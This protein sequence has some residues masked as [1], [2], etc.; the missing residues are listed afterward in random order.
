[1]G[2]SPKHKWMTEYMH[3]VKI[4]SPGM[5]LTTQLPV[6]LGATFLAVAVGA[7]A[8]MA[9]LSAHQLQ[10]VC[11][12]ALLAL[13]ILLVDK[14]V[15]AIPTIL[16]P[17]SVLFASL[18]LGSIATSGI[19]EQQFP[20]YL[21]LWACEI[22]G[23]L[24]GILVFPSLS[25]PASARRSYVDTERLAKHTQTIWIIC[26]LAA[27]LFFVIQGIPALLPNVEESR[28]A[29]AVS[30]TGYLRLLAYMSGP[31]S[32]ILLAIRGRKA[33]PYLAGAVIVILALADRSPL[34]YFCLPIVAIAALAGRR[35]VRSPQLM[36]ASALL[37]SLVAGIG[38]YRI[39]S[40][41]EFRK[42]SEYNQAI[43]NHDYLSVALTS[44]EH[45]ASVIPENAVLTKKLV[46]E[47][48][49]HY[50]WGQTY[51]TLF[52][53]ALHSKPLSPDLLIKKVS[54]KSFIGG[55]TPPTL[56]GE[57][58][59]NGGLPGVVLAAFGLMLLL[60]YW[61]SSLLGARGSGTRE[62]LRV[63]AVIYG[64]VVAWGINA[65][66]A[67]L[68]GASTVPLAGFL[69]LIVLR[70]LSVVRTARDR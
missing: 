9:V 19:T 15:V 25:R 67:G 58:Y 23:F 40:Q 2:T 60:R 11:G 49:I 1:M 17:A 68:A 51:L 50:E 12:F 29:T 27:F 45:Y 4:Q 43:A 53:E 8:S 36:I 18:I 59:M 69:F 48:K 63:T 6:L 57:G 33:W 26:L 61:A 41:K 22:G 31:A 24:L 14:N 56:A 65:Q 13:V 16:R 35:R 62:E 39:F 10:L 37:L 5:P 32:L 55:G 20:Q 30:G 47:G 21:D 46:D 7:A 52:L 70:R 64:Y 38:T 28:V 42:Y 44:V 66:V 54:G 34:L 3:S